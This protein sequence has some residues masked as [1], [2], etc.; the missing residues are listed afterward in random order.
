VVII[1]LPNV[2]AILLPPLTFN[3]HSNNQILFTNN[4]HSNTQFLFTKNYHSPFPTHLSIY[5]LNMSLLLSFIICAFQLFHIYFN[6]PI[7]RQNDNWKWIDGVHFIF[8]ILKPLR[9]HLTVPSEK[10]IWHTKDLDGDK[11]TRE[12]QQTNG[13]KKIELQTTAKD[14][15]NVQTWNIKYG[16]WVGGANRQNKYS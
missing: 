9:L 3:C 12:I 11:S 2:L 13:N 15:I 16:I 7:H 6:S 8:N 10:Y 14:Q 1:W 5:L 4:C